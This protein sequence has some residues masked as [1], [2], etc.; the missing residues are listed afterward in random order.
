MLLKKYA[1]EKLS[2]WK[3][4]LS[5]YL[6]SVGGKFVLC[7]NLDLKKLPVGLLTYYKECLDCF[8]ECSVAMK[9]NENDLTLDEIA[10]AV[11]QE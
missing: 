3:K 5:Y 11:V 6:K 7:C 4:I 2:D 8:A 1:N 10:N 9:T